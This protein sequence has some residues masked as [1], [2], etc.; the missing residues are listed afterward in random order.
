VPEALAGADVLRAARLRALASPT[1]NVTVS[2]R[3]AR[4]RRH[5][6]PALRRETETS[7]RSLTIC[8]LGLPAA[9]TG[10]RSNQEG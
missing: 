3:G 4:P 6:K 5:P 9:W 2:L 10:P 8:P 7:P 1:A